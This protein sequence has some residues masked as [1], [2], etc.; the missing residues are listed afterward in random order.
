MI[1]MTLLMLGF[2]EIEQWTYRQLRLHHAKV[3]HGY[4]KQ[5]ACAITAKVR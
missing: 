4:L 3:N 2:H 5:Y 1:P